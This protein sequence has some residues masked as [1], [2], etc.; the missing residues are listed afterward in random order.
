MVVNSSTETIFGTC[1]LTGGNGYLGT[2]VR[3][4]L[5]ACG[6]KVATLGRSENNALV[7]DLS[8]E[9]PVINK[10][11]DIVVHCA[12]KA[13]S[14]PKNE[15]ERKA[16]FDVNLIGTQNLLTALEAAPG[17]PKHFVFMSSVSVYGLNQGVN[18]NETQPLQSNYPYGKSK[19]EA[20]KLIESWCRQNRV[21]C[22]I[23]RLPLLAGKNPPGNLKMMIEGIKK[24]YYFNIS[25]EPVRKSIVMAED[26]AKLI[27][28][29][30][31][32]TGTFNL[33]DGYHPSFQELATLIAKQLRKPKPLS[34]PNWLCKALIFSSKAFSFISPIN[35]YKFQKLTLSLTFDDSKARSLLRWNP[36]SVLEAFKL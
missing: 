31:G 15:H 30:I 34:I 8:V 36:T 4:H 1:L 19:I 13:H 23:L 21:T 22:L 25:K 2:Y 18:V 29:T 33:T 7:A 16:F 14:F 17:L 9:M 3:Q 32:M 26:V 11:F 6:F 10:S 12:G 24:G 20:E 5:D 27:P 28:T 35:A